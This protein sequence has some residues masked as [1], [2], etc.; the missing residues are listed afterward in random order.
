MHAIQQWLSELSPS[1]R[2][3]DLGCGPGSMKQ[4]MAGLTV[5][6]IDVD[7]KLLAATRDRTACAAWARACL[8][9]TGVST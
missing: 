8:S 1:Q 6:G 9:R 5:V 3:L 4:Q 2:V 7:G